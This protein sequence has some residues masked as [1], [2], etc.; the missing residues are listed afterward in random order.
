MLKLIGFF[1]V[2]CV[3]LSCDSSKDISENE[4]FTKPV[5]IPFTEYNLAGTSCQWTNLAYNG[6]I[7]IINSNKEMEKYVECSNGSYP[8]ID[9]SK[10]TL[11]LASGGTGNGI[12]KID[13]TITQIA[14]NKYTLKVIVHLNFAMVVQTWTIS[15][16]IPKVSNN[17][18][19]VL[20]RENTFY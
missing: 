5:E 4:E 8:A 1:T 17:T 18:T 11:L 13:K 2:A 6:K 15:I 19:V 3:S 14:A 10:Y 16:L 7:I 20:D 12:S 9:F